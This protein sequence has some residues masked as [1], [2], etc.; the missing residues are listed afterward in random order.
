MMRLFARFPDEILVQVFSE[1][2]DLKHVAKFGMAISS[3]LDEETFDQIVSHPH[4]GSEMSGQT[5][6][7]FRIYV[8]E[9]T[10]R[11]LEKHFCGVFEE[12]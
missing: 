3:K 2:F 11:S 4:F 5:Y 12:T 9:T 8:D 10:S 6:S 7:R 1:Q